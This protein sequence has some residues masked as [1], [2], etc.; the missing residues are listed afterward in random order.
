MLKVLVIDESRSRAG[1]ICAGLAMAGHQVVAVLVS[2]DELA[3]NVMRIRPDIIL[4]DTEAP[5][6]DT[7]EHLAAMNRDMPRPVI[8]FTQESDDATIRKAIDAGVAAYVVDGLAPG[9]FKSVIDVAIARFETHQAL[10]RELHEATRKLSDRKL[11][12]RAKG[13]LMKSR[14]L[15]EETAYASLRRLAMDRSQP[16]ANVAKDVVDMAKLLL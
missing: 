2:S 11:I 14:N 7:L 5:S 9:R 15:D 16:L 13:I 8:I 1:D 3:A 4:I 12:D 6:R 10:N